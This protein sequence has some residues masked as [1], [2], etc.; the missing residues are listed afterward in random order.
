MENVIYWAFYKI[1]KPYMHFSG[2]NVGCRAQSCFSPEGTAEIA[3]NSFS[4]PFG[5]K[6]PPN[7]SPNVET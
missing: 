1:S 3:A 4:R 6:T 2:F 7:I 5:T